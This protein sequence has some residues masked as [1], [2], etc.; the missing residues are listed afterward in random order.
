[1]GKYYDFSRFLED[2][3]VG[4]TPRRSASVETFLRLRQ[5]IF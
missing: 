2:G 4:L 3:R 1:M 5:T